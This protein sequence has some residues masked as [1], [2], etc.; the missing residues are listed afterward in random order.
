MFL[1][2]LPE[3]ITIKSVTTTY[4]KYVFFFFSKWGNGKII[5]VRGSHSL[6]VNEKG[7]L[8]TIMM[9]MRTEET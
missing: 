2:F 3:A 9:K 1:I 6:R 5:W 8:R 4:S 7:R